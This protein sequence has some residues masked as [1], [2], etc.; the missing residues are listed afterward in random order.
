MSLANTI[1]EIIRRR[2]GI[3]DRELS[4]SIFGKRE[5]AQQINGEC[6][7]LVNLG[8]LERRKVDCESIG[9][10]LVRQA[11]VLTVV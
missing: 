7:H 4:E 2:P 5:R 3:S 6:R 11:P 1:I 10:Y 8:R 9:N